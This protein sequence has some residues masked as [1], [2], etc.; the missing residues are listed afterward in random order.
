M[1]T[2]FNGFTA[3][4]FSTRELKEMQAEIERVLK[5]REEEREKLRRQYQ[6]KLNDL[7]N[8]IEN[9]GFYVGMPDYPS[10]SAVVLEPEED[11]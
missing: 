8:T 5:E 4:V 3:D 7:L 2:L 11:D 9:D 1:K 6:E 10:F